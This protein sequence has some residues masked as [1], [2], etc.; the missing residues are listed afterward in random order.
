MGGSALTADIPVPKN[1]PPEELSREIPV[2]YVPARNTLFLA[3]ALGLAETEGAADIFL[4]VN[5]LDYSGYPDCRLEYVAAFR[6]SRQSGDL[7]RASRA[8]RHSEFTLR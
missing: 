7:R 3:Y 2:T 5:A 6:A 4:G 8:R 1:R